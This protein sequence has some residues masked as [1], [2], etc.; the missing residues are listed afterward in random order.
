[1]KKHY[2]YSFSKIM[3]YSDT[4]QQIV[5]D[6]VESMNNG[7]YE[8]LTDCINDTLDNSLIYYKDQW[9]V[10]QDFCTPQDANWDY[11]MDELYSLIYSA[12]YEEEI[13]EDEDEE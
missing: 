5:I 9:D 4:T 13:D 1:M 3:G 7:D 12:I 8:D 6:V 10:L 11:A 2:E